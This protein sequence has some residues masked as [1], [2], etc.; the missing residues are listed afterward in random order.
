M[1]AVDYALVQAAR[2]HM[3]HC[4]SL[5]FEEP[6]LCTDELVDEL[7]K[8]MFAALSEVDD[9]ESTPYELFLAVLLGLTT[10][11]GMGYDTE[12]EK[13]TRC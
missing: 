13:I 8:R 5:L 2:E 11:R 4:T 3:K 6:E 12:T 7:E 9:L 1:S 10:E